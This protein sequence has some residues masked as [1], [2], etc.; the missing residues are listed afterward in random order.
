MNE[1]LAIIIIVIAC[2]AMFFAW[3]LSMATCPDKMVDLISGSGTGGSSGCSSSNESKEL[4]TSRDED[5]SHTLI[6]QTSNVYL[7]L[8]GSKRAGS[9]KKLSVVPEQD[10][11]Q[12][13]VTSISQVLHPLNIQQLQHR[14]TIEEEDDIEAGPPSAD[15]T[16][17]PS[18][19]NSLRQ[20]NMAT[21]EVV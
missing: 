6:A 8:N 1:L 14:Y 11:Q 3:L 17:V 4:I 2:C 19:C 20:L 21:V 13:T 7:Q 12:L 10:E 15:I 5:D 9:H 18:R 16:P